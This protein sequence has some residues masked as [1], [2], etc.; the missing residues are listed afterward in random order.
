[1]TEHT[2]QPGWA[3]NDRT[4]QWELHDRRGV[5]YAWV[6]DEMLGRFDGDQRMALHLFGR[7]GTVPPPMQHHVDAASAE[8]LRQQEARGFPW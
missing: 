6:T 4:G 1:M 5:V 3:H 8:A 2:T 7:M